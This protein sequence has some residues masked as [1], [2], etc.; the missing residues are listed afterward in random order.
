MVKS[1]FRAF[2]RKRQAAIPQHRRLTQIEAQKI[3]DAG[4]ASCPKCDRNQEKKKFLRLQTLWGSALC[5]STCLFH[6]CLSS[7]MCSGVIEY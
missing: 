2:V 5:S 6:R 1:R 4:M 3:F 7:N